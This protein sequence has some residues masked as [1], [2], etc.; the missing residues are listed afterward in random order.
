MSHPATARA[1]PTGTGTVLRAKKP[2]H[3]PALPRRGDSREQAM[4]GDRRGPPP[5]DTAPAAPP[6][7]PGRRR[8]SRRAQR[9]GP[10]PRGS[11]PRARRC[12]GS[13]VCGR[14]LERAAAAV[15]HTGGG[16]AGRVSGV[17]P[18]LLRRVVGADGEVGRVRGGAVVHRDQDSNRTLTTRITRKRGHPPECGQMRPGPTQC[19][20]PSPT[21]TTSPLPTKRHQPSRG[22]GALIAYVGPA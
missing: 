12:A 17:A 19:S 10:V 1:R 11:R 18:A 15:E 22:V 21:G 8:R 2:E 16:R 13:A 20:T 5:R 9:C 4:A 7:R 6:Q 3:R 14:R